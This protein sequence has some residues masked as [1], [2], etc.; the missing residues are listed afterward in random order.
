MKDR[1]N[2]I[3][4]KGLTPAIIV[5]EREGV[6]LIK[7]DVNNVDTSVHILESK[8]MDFIDFKAGG[9]MYAKDQKMT[10][11]PEEVIFMIYALEKPWISG[12]A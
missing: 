5:T 4:R 2:N 6:G 10:F 3:L 8:R 12:D 1:I 11:L 7:G 9:I